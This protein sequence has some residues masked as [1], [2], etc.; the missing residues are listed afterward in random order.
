MIFLVRRLKIKNKE[1]ILYDVEL[2]KNKDSIDLPLT[3]I[4][5]GKNG[6]GKSYL[7]KLLV[8]VFKLIEDHSRHNELNK[9]TK[10]KFRYPEFEITYFLNG[11]EYFVKYIN[12]EIYVYINNIRAELTGEVLPSKII[13]ISYLSNDKFTF[14][15]NSDKE[16]IYRYL[17]IKETSNSSYANTIEKRL[18]QT[19][20]NS[21]LLDGFNRKVME[22]L[23]FLDYKRLLVVKYKVKT[24]LAKGKV[25]GLDLTKKIDKLSKGRSFRNYQVIDEK[26]KNSDLL[27][28]DFYS[29]LK[30]IKNGD[31]DEYIKIENDNEII[32]TITPKIN[33]DMA[34]NLLEKYEFLSIYTGLGLVES[35][36]ISLMKRDEVSFDSTSSG[37]KHYIYSILS[38]ASEID[39]NSL[40]LIDEPEISLHPTWQSQYVNNLK[41]VFGKFSNT[42]FILATHSHFLVSDLEP[43][44]STLVTVKNEVDNNLYDRI[45][46]FE[47]F[48]TYGWSAE[49]IL[50][51]VFDMPTTRNY[52]LANEI[53]DL[54][55]TLSDSSNQISNETIMRIKRL[56]SIEP[57]IKEYDP[58]KE[59]LISLLN[60]VQ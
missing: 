54:V 36:K 59:I 41:N 44:S 1:R 47:D 31:F 14:S 2:T 25:S 52:Y 42:H 11:N 7:L 56:K 22:T 4:V 26:F 33:N 24:N 60:K 5:I 16:S 43:K 46:S 39:N 48:S 30:S 23:T 34:Y 32:F 9:K 29:F 50:L 17:G 27:I 12:S 15:D 8:D 19:I 21:L 10:T 57:L 3:T 20:F 35:P 51:N 58:L 45:C 40:I 6:A 28:D 13:A 49:N 55:S 38:I 37:E 53:G 18:I